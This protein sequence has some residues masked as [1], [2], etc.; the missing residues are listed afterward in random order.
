MELSR[1]VA[2]TYLLVHTAALGQWSWRRI[3]FGPAASPGRRLRALARRLFAAESSLVRHA[4]T[5][6]YM[7]QCLTGPLVSEPTRRTEQQ[8]VQIFWGPGVEEH[9]SFYK[10]RN[11]HSNQL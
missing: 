2:T 6:L 11:I 8:I 1:N 7:L 3:P 4:C 10:K 9:G 5:R